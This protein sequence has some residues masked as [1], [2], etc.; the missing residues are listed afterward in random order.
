MRR[1]PNALVILLGCV[2][3]GV[4]PLPLRAAEDYYVDSQRGT[5]WEGGGSSLS[6]WRTLTFALARVSG[7]LATLHVAAG[8]HDL[9]L[10]EVFP[11]VV[12]P[13]LSIRGAGR[14]ETVIDAGGASEAFSLRSETYDGATV[15][16]QLTVR[17]ALN[18]IASSLS[19]DVV[20]APRLEDVGVSGC[21]VGIYLGA[22]DGINAPDLVSCRLT[23]NRIGVYVT[24]AFA[25]VAAPVIAN[26]IIESNLET[27]VLITAYGAS[28]T[29]VLINDTLAFNGTAGLASF[30]ATPEPVVRNCILYSNVS[31]LQNIEPQEIDHSDISDGTY[32]GMNGNIALDPLFRDALQGDFRLVALSPCIDA[33]AAGPPGTLEPSDAY[34]AP[35]LID[36][37]LDLEA[38][39]D[40]GA[41]E[42]SNVELALS[43][44][45]SPGSTFTLGTQG[46]SSLDVFMIIGL[47]TGALYIDPFGHLLV[48][49]GFGPWLVLGWGKIPSQVDLAI[50]DDPALSGIEIYFQAWAGRVIAGYGNFSN[51]IELRIL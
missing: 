6:P 47:Q 21:D 39:L 34:D 17:A 3:W 40:M 9:A 46:L 26:A 4:S 45:F 36:G 22:S 15:I 13:G 42:F 24:A 32:A 10:G 41:H 20:S 50:P 37:N 1:L 28:V 16:S 35:R 8:L 23:G 27:G 44:G 51:L 5:D 49:P 12:P 38:E 48:V 11:L 29:P 25:G 2:L 33:G 30:T 14:G 7:P 19:T 31:D 18:G 43:G